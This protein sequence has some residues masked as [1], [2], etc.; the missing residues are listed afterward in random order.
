MQNWKGS[1]RF[2]P[3]FI[4][5]RSET[6]REINVIAKCNTQVCTIPGR[7]PLS[8]NANSHVLS[9][10]QFQ[11]N[12]CGSL[13]PA[14]KLVFKTKYFC[15]SQD[16]PYFRAQRMQFD[17]KSNKYKQRSTGLQQCIQF[18]TLPTFPRKDMRTKGQ[19]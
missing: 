17:S 14:N 19:Y 9:M 18:L 2:L 4:V 12:Y 7:E 13:A 10:S 15:L 8:S 11:S 3:D 16:H 6:K 1:H 5:E